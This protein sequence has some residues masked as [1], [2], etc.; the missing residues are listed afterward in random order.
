MPEQGAPRE[1]SGDQ[2]AVWTSL[3]FGCRGS[4]GFCGPVASAGPTSD[5]RFLLH[6]AQFPGTVSRHRRLSGE[7]QYGGTSPLFTA[8]P[9]AVRCDVCL[10]GAEH[11]SSSRQSGLGVLTKPR[12]LRT[13]IHKDSHRIWDRDAGAGVGGARNRVAQGRQHLS[14]VWC[15]LGRP[16]HAKRGQGVARRPPWPRGAHA[17]EGGQGG[18]QSVRS[19]AESAALGPGSGRRL[20]GTQ[21]PLGTCC[22]GGITHRPAQR[23]VP[24]DHSLSGGGELS[25]PVLGFQAWPSHSPL[26][27][28]GSFS[29]K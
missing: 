10:G 14:R 1:G 9:A 29:I 4:P 2:L 28:L 8:D 21:Q 18:W 24:W 25:G 5:F 16:A 22:E 6:L 11:P 7:V 19:R 3:S 23:E 13:L 26:L 27:G 15:P 12:R 20:P 17:G